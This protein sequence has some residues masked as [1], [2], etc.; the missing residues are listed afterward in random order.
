MQ[1]TINEVA[2]ALKHNFGIA[3][4]WTVKDSILFAA[5][6]PGVKH[7]TKNVFS[8]EKVIPLSLADLPSMDGVDWRDFYPSHRGGKGGGSSGVY[9]LDN[10][11]AEDYRRLQIQ[12]GVA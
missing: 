11:D 7:L 3:G 4:V 1:H 10:L 12:G 8:H 2:E 5:S 6:D 9:K